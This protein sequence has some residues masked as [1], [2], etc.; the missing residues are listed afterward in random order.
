MAS[1]QAVQ[2]TVDEIRN[3]MISER[4]SPRTVK[5]YSFLVGVFLKFTKKPLEQCN[6]SDIE[7]Y[8]FY[9]ATE[10]NYSKNSQYLAVQ[11][12][13]Y[14]MKA[15]ELKIPKNLTPPK[16]SRKIPVYLS[17]RESAKLLKESEVNLRDYAMVSI[18]LNS[19]LR[20]S[21]LCNL[22]IEDIEFESG[23]IT[24]HGGKGDK[25]RITLVPDQTMGI[26]KSYFMSR[27]A[28]NK[29][30]PFFFISNK[31]GMFHPSTIEKIIRNL[32]TGAGIRRRVTPH[33]LRHT[34][35]TNILRNGGDIR[36]IQALLGHSSISTTE[37]YTHIDS[38]TMREMYR[39][40]GPKYDSE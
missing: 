13:K 14:A 32:A 19:G 21:E 34:F 17:Q 18:F 36:F 39:K 40:Y 31:G 29:A 37:I 27:L 33:T 16:R 4:R 26:L 15:K 1:D 25:E 5:Q 23:K 9:L 6:S 20:V 10:R 22:K 7:K 28:K 8:K 3:I 30:S 12:L 24:V 38:E 35:A 11:A 2:N